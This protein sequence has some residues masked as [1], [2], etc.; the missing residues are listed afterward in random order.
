MKNVVAQC[1]VVNVFLR[2]VDERNIEK[3]LT[4]QAVSRSQTFVDS[5][6]TILGSLAFAQMSVLEGG[7]ELRDSSRGQD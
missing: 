3:D 4:V 2:F 1:E 5:G 6:S 7:S